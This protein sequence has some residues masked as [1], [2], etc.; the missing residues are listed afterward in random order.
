LERRFYGAVAFVWLHELGH[1]LCGHLDL[2][3]DM[4]RRLELSETEISFGESEVRHTTAL[5]PSLFLYGLE[6]QAD[7]WAS[8]HW[9]RRG[10]KAAS[11]NDAIAY[12][13]GAMA[14][15]LLLQGKGCWGPG[16]SLRGAS[17]PAPL[18]RLILPYGTGVDA[19]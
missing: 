7:V 1:V 4:D 6:I 11:P 8:R 13:L 2:M 9:A 5:D 16:C 17:P 18:S 3:Q 15:F 10:A 12:V 19:R 14:V